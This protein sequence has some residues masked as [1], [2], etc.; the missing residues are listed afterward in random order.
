MK[1]ELSGFLKQ[2]ISSHLLLEK[3]YVV[4]LYIDGNR[5]AIHTLATSEITL[6]Q[7]NGID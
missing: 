2:N 5:V 3:T 1:W 7:I 6:K 4:Q